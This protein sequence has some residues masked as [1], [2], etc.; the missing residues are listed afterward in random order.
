MAAGGIQAFIKANGALPGKRFVVAGTGPFLLPVAANIAE[1]GG[2]VVAV[3]EAASLANWLPHLG[4]ASGVPGKALEGAEYAGI[5]AKHQ[6]RYRTRTVV[7]QVLGEY[8]RF[9][10]AHRQGR[11]RRRR[12]RGHR[13]AA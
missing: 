12:H 4:A 1:A 13:T 9:L 10:G 2:K 8:R 3:C 5:F 6:I 7:T 11:R